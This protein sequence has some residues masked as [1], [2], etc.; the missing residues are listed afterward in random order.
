MFGFRYLFSDLYAGAIWAGTENPKDSGNFTSTKLPASCA[1]DAPI[2]CTTVAGSSFP[3]LGFIFSFGQDNRKDMF[4]LAS[5]GVYRIARP[6]RCNY[7][8]SVENVTAPLPSSPSPSHS[9]GKRFS[10]PP[11]AVLLNTLISAS[12]LLLLYFQH[13]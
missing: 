2:P 1:H 11:T 10:K 6:S 5:S 13:I 7:F 9:A 8:C 4:I 12:L 3:S